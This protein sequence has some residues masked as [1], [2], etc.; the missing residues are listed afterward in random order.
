MGWIYLVL[1]LSKLTHMPQRLSILLSI[2]SNSC[3][4]FS[5]GCSWRLRLLLHLGAALLLE[6]WIDHP[7]NMI[8]SYGWRGTFSDVKWRI[9]LFTRPIWTIKPRANSID[10][11]WRDGIHVYFIDVVEISLLMAP[12]IPNPYS[13]PCVAFLKSWRVQHLQISTKTVW[14][15]NLQEYWIFL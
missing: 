14:Q 10:D 7:G 6:K 4:R 3:Q 11:N 15:H 1:Y 13:F 12:R 2:C 8:I 5:V 9:L